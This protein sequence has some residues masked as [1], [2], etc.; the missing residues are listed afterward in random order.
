[1]SNWYL[2]VEPGK[3]S[4][5]ATTDLVIEAIRAG[6]VPAGTLVCRKGE[7]AWRPI[8]TVAE[9]AGALGAAARPLV[10]APTPPLAASPEPP[11]KQATP[12]PAAVSRGRLAFVGRP[13]TIAL[14]LL[15]LAVIM[16]GAISYRSIRGNIHDPTDV[17][18]EMLPALLDEAA[19]NRA[20]RCDHLLDQ[21]KEFQAGK[22]YV[23]QP[24]PGSVT[25][26]CKAV[27]M[28]QPA[29]LSHGGF[30]LDSFEDCTKL[31]ADLPKDLARH[32]NDLVVK[33]KLFCSADGKPTT[34]PDDS[35]Q[36]AAQIELKDNLARV[37]K[38]VN[39]GTVSARI[40]ACYT[41]V[42]K[43]L[44]QS[45]ERIRKVRCDLLTKDT[46][47]P[48]VTYAALMDHAYLHE[49]YE[50]YKKENEALHDQLSKQDKDSDF[51]DMFIESEK[52]K[53]CQTEAE[54]PLEAQQA[55][56]GTAAAT[57]M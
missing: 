37:V 53:A 10:S 49:R 18:K 51:Y 7:T 8:T 44:V 54:S 50:Q 52:T 20:V 27:S 41:D 23:A 39:S 35:A 13:A 15:G 42:K 55:A 38:N 11:E 16:L 22:P 25:Q 45:S 4:G 28:G 2:E 17:S 56:A 34:E 21:L 46:K 32:E 14:G 19:I 1:M 24:I 12:A 3:M 48:N 9:F 36:L 47:L 33:T 43:E 26:R 5:P 29:G 40:F 57:C 30:F 31:Q 6:R